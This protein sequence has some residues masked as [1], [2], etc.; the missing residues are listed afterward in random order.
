[1]RRWSVLSL[2]ALA[3]RLSRAAALAR[4]D[5]SVPMALKSPQRDG[6]AP[7]SGAP[8][9]GVHTVV[10]GAGAAGLAAAHFLREH[11]CSVVVVEGRARVGGRAYSVGAN[12]YDGERAFEGVDRGAHWVHGGRNNPITTAY[13]DHFGIERVGVGGDST[14]EGERRNCC[15]FCAASGQWA[16]PAYVDAS[17]DLFAF[18]M[19]LATAYFRQRPGAAGDISVA[20]AITRASKRAGIFLDNRSLAFMRWHHALKFEGDEAAPTANVSM[21]AE[22]FS[23]YTSFY[24]DGCDALSNGGRCTPDQ[25]DQVIVGGYSQ[26][27]A[28]L[29]RDL[30]HAIL[31]N[32]SV[33]SIRA[34]HAARDTR[35]FLETSAGPLVADRVIVTLPLGVL[36][37]E[38]VRFRPPLSPRKTRAIRELGFG[39]IT[40]VVVSA[41]LCASARL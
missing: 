9:G 21:R 39:S 41:R 12:V 24:P 15:V 36:K 5:D 37:S 8:C 33:T 26:L 25:G 23:P 35:V 30:D 16:A 38:R 3:A 4:A 22:A 27:M 32:T 20:D 29:S 6:S 34:P 18:Q 11:N 28:A 40:K 19:A 13:L 7:A 14:Y 31:L 17:F 10:V 2:L 1:M